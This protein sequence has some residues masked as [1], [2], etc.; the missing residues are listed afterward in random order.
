MGFNSAF[1]GL[2]CSVVWPHINPVLF[3]VCIDALCI[4]TH[5]HTHTIVY[6][7]VNFS[8]LKQI[9][10]ALVAIIK[11]W[12]H[13]GYLV[14]TVLFWDKKTVRVIPS[15]L[16]PNGRSVAK[17]KITWFY[18]IWSQLQWPQKPSGESCPGR[19]SWIQTRPQS[20][21]LQHHC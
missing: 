15:P 12:I 3:C 2:N 19:V 21:I 1:K 4:D 9:N 18:C 20:V 14:T 13:L 7:K 16:T 8:I 17:K 11:D 10:C 5:T 6:F